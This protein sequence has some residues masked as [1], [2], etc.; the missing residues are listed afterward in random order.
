MKGELYRAI[1]VWVRLGEKELA[2]YRCFEVL[3]SGKF[4]VQSK[5]FFRPPFDAKK[6][7]E[8]QSRFLEL[9]ADVAPEERDDLFDSL[10]E[11]IEEHDAGFAN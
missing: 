6:C 3:A 7:L 4:C 9:L 10:E 2:C 1:D 11:A 5:D 8:H